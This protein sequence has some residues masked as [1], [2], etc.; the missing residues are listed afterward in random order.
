MRKIAFLLCLMILF[1]G[2]AK[3]E[4]VSYII[5]NK[6]DNYILYTSKKNQLLDYSFDDYE[7]VGDKGY[8]IRKEDKSAYISKDGDELLPLKQYTSLEVLYEM[9]IETNEDDQI[10]I[11][12]SDGE[13]LYQDND[14]TAIRLDSLPII[15]TKEGTVLLDHQGN[16]VEIKDEAILSA[17]NIG[18]FVFISYENATVFKN[19]AITSQE[20]DLEIPYSGHF[21][22]LQANLDSGFLLYDKSA[23]NLVYSN[24]DGTIHFMTNIT[25]DE[26]MIDQGDNIVGK[27][28]RNHILVNQSGKVVSFNN[29]YYD[30]DHYVKKN[31]S[32]PY[33]PHIIVNEGKEI[34][35]EGVQLNPVSGYT[36]VPLFPVYIRLEGYGYYNFDGTK[37]FDSVFDQ[38][39]DFDIYERAIVTKGED[40]YLIDSHGNKMTGNYYDVKPIA[41]G[42]YAA[43][44]DGD[45]YYV[46]DKDGNEVLPD[47]YMGDREIVRSQNRVYGIFNRSGRTYVYDMEELSELFNHEGDMH[48]DKQGFLVAENG[49]CY[50]M[51]GTCFYEK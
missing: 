34:E 37:A 35:I 9:V 10:T 1:S 14:D 47:F 7:M 6:K 15:E 46:I 27:K 18:D 23:Q 30:F 33:G 13:M 49:S 44:E 5:K 48:F 42:Y 36:Y 12:N 41:E 24:I 51:D 21:S 43:Y 26:I 3:T 28:G 19:Y 31:T 32:I 22:F 8:L 4:E 2:C 40:T 50:L 25:I 39:G 16:E 20:D 38:A 45:K 11:Y 29:Y 17:G